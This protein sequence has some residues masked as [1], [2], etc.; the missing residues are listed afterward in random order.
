M[1]CNTCN[2]FPC[3]VGAKSDAEVCCLRHATMQPTVTLWTRA[4]VRRL[5]TNGCVRRV[6]AVEVERMARRFASRRRSWSSHAVP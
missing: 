4:F 3:K 1:L 5:L 6:T 2:S